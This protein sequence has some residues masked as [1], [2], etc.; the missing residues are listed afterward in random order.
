MLPFYHAPFTH[1]TI[2]RSLQASLWV[3]ERWGDQLQETHSGT[4]LLAAAA[5]QVTTPAR[6]LHFLDGCTP[7]LHPGARPSLFLRDSGEVPERRPRG[8]DSH[9]PQGQAQPQVGESQQDWKDHNCPC[10]LPGPASSDTCRPLAS[11]K[12]LLWLS[13]FFGL[14]KLFGYSLPYS[15]FLLLLLLGSYLLLLSL[16]KMITGEVPATKRSLLD[17]SD[18]QEEDGKK[19]N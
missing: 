5:R 10:L 17:T 2:T 15:S 1:T 7:H 9:R 8:Q 18:I 4:G 14:L 12:V 13:M 19:T 16:A 3:S 11:K 6:T